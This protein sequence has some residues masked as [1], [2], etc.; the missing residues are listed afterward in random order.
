MIS[1]VILED[2]DG[3]IAHQ[4]AAPWPLP[5]QVGD[6]IDYMEAGAVYK[7][8]SVTWS[9]NKLHGDH[10]LHQEVKAKQMPVV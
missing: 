3:Q 9:V 8:E 6:T 4:E 1:R 10:E 2:S 7:V 5:L